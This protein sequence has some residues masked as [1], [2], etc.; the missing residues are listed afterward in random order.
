MSHTESGYERG[1]RSVTVP[2]SASY[3][4]IQQGNGKRIFSTTQPPEH[5]NPTWSKYG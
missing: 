4:I 2:V 5:F 1:K 3:I